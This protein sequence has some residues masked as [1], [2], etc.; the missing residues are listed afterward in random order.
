MSYVF[1]SLCHLTFRLP[2][3]FLLS[4]ALPSSSA[5]SF[6][7]F[8]PA[9]SV[10]C[11]SWSQGSEAISSRHIRTANYCRA[12]C[13]DGRADVIHPR[14]VLSTNWRKNLAPPLHFVDETEA[15]GWKV[16]RAAQPA[17]LESSSFNS[18]ASRPHPCA[19]HD[20]CLPVWHTC[21]C[22]SNACLALCTGFE[23]WFI[24]LLFSTYFELAI[25]KLIAGYE[26][27]RET[28]FLPQTPL[29]KSV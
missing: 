10:L 2:F 6:W 5:P 27:L 13:T 21:Q 24:P 12:D 8:P 4:S 14:P 3:A 18:P 23:S 15:H 26:R 9:L 1:M 20:R 29:I 25:W 7:T 16:V 22:H 19:W 17:G 11:C 28:G